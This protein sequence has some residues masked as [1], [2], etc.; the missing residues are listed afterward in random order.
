MTAQKWNTNPRPVRILLA[1]RKECQYYG[2]IYEVERDYPTKSA[3]VEFRRWVSL[4]FTLCMSL[5][6][7]TFHAAHSVVTQSNG[8]SQAVL[9]NTTSN[10][11]FAL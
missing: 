11:L 9:Q 5:A 6:S 7:Y 10:I 8:I 4:Y 2:D 3:L 1:R